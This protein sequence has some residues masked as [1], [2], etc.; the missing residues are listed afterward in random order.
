MG[1]GRWARGGAGLFIFPATEGVRCQNMIQEQGRRP[2]A[3]PI[4]FSFRFHANEQANVPN[5]SHRA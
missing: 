1:G 2:N 5:M 3:H 4:S